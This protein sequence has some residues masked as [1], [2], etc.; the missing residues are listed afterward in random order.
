MMMLR[1]SLLAFSLLAATALL[2]SAR[3]TSGTGVATQHQWG[4]MDKCAKQAIAKFPDH[5]AEDLAKRDNLTRQ[6]Q[7]NSRVPTRDG[8][9]PK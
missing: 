1:L 8:S 2:D 3:A 9:A 4:V 6:C 7:R 5:T